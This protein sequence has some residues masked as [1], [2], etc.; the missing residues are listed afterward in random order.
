MFVTVGLRSVSAFVC[1]LIDQFHR[2][3]LTGIGR[4]GYKTEQKH[5][6]RHEKENCGVNHRPLVEVMEGKR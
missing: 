1:R 3:R 5:A 4:A 2:F 6:L